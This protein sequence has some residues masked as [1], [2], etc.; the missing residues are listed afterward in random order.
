MDF[1]VTVA[2]RGLAE[3]TTK[4]YGQEDDAIGVR[5]AVP[6]DGD[7]A[8]GLTKTRVDV[9][10]QAVSKIYTTTEGNTPGARGHM[11]CTEIVR[12]QAEASNTPR[13]VVRD[14]GAQ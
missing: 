6:L 8:R 4:V 10:D 3:L 7:Q 2:A 13:V 11:D 9:R 14:D 12:D 5:E 1:D